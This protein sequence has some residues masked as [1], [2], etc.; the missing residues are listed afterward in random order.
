MTKLQRWWTELVDRPYRPGLQI[1]QYILERVLGMGSYGITYLTTNQETGR[2][3]VL[4]Q[5][6]PSKRKGKKGYPIFQREANI[7]RKLNHP[8]FPALL[9]Q[10]QYKKQYFIAMEYIDGL[11]IEDII[12]ERGKTYTEREA[13]GFILELLQPVKELHRIGLVHRDIRL[14]NVLVSK[15]QLYLIDFGLAQWIGESP[16]AAADDL[17]EYELEKQLRREVEFKSDFYSMGHFLLF[18]LYTTYEGSETKDSSTTWEEELNIS[19]FTRG[20]IR[21][22]LQFDRPFLDASALEAEI[23]HGLGCIGSN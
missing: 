8:S 23:I 4:K 18:L 11:S 2:R 1:K 10:F 7:L 16:T 17:D 20:L 22:M 12:F 21:R 13:L 14:P 5:V 19:Q 6:R 3:C 9:D 15:D